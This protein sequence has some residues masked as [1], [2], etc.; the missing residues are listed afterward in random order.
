MRILE[1]VG[2]IIQLGGLLA[3]LCK[4]VSCARFMGGNITNSIAR[5]SSP[6]Y[7]KYKFLHTHV[8]AVN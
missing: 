2:T 8:R 5:T 4:L 3:R 6:H 7:S 1:G